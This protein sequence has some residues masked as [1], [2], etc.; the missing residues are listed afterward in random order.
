MSW[1]VWYTGIVGFLLLVG[2]G[3]VAYTLPKVKPHWRGAYWLAIG[4]AT[5]KLAA[6]GFGLAG[7]LGMRVPANAVQWTLLTSIV[8]VALELILVPYIHRWERELEDDG[9]S[10]T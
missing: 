3:S 8:L 1:E 6:F 4:L 9:T 10:T 5:F 2:L 7:L